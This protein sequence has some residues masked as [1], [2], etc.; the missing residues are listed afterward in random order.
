MFVEN[1]VMLLITF[2][3][4]STGLCFTLNKNCMKTQSYVT[5]YAFP[6]WNSSIICLVFYLGKRKC[7]SNQCRLN[8]LTSAVWISVNWS[9][10]LASL[11]CKKLVIAFL[12]FLFFLKSHVC[13]SVYFKFI[14]SRIM[15]FLKAS[16]WVHKKKEFF[17]EFREFTEHLPCVTGS[18]H[19][20]IHFPL[21]DNAVR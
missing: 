1:T 21:L 9:F 18:A 11:R 14:Q 2:C 13:V 7:S 4:S 8:C 12:P 17:L 15:K 20:C 10:Y 16:Q 3:F 5:R 19:T 6:L